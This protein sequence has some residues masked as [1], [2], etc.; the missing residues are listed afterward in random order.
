M[1]EGAVWSFTT[2]GPCTPA[3]THVESIACGV[4]RSG[5]AYKASVQVRIHDDCGAPVVGATVTGQL[6]GTYAE[7]VSAA[8]GSDG[9]AVLVSTGTSKKPAYT[10]TVQGVTHATLSYDPA[11]NVETSDSY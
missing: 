4:V 9:V 1:T 7:T 11:A 6:S 10:F 8:T 2:A 3:A 5:G